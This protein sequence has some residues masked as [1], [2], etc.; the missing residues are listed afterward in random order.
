[1]ELDE[2][3]NGLSKT[4]WYQIFITY[5]IC[6]CRDGQIEMA[7]SALQVLKKSA[8]FVSDSAIQSRIQLFSLAVA[9]YSGNNT[10][11]T[12]K[13]NELI[14]RDSKEIIGLSMYGV[15]HS[16]G[17]SETP[18]VDQYG[19]CQKF[20][21]RTLDRL[22]KDHPAYVYALTCNAYFSLHS[23]FTS[24]AIPLLLEAYRL[25]KDDPVLPL[26][27]GVTFIT[28]SMH[29]RSGN[30][31]EYIMR[32]FAWIFKYAELQNQT[33]EAY[34]NIARAFHH[35]GLVHL[36]VRWYEKV[37]ASKNTLMKEAAYNLS[38]IYILV[39]SNHLAMEL[40]QKYLTF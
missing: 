20:I 8:I 7:L 29:S 26:C 19:K 24:K 27:L 9:V 2:T 13:I 12:S 28:K 11:I 10:F 35:I 3:I 25:K 36:A 18:F 23:G 1:M 17:S 38:S 32:G 4:Q 30:R 15:F 33:S 16:L 5:S 40:Y 21:K 34:Y 37:L 14:T 6:S 31:H 39:G 22:K